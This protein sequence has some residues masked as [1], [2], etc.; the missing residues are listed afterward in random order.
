[1]YDCVEDTLT[2]TLTSLPVNAYHGN[3][4]ADFVKWVSTYD[5][6][7][8]QTALPKT[9]LAALQ[10]LKRTQNQMYFASR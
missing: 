6:R 5:F 2:I 7:M 8:I 9:P 3:I 1:M 4:R 10:E